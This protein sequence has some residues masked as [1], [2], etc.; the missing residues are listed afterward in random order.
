MSIVRSPIDSFIC[1]FDGALRAVS[2]VAV[3][4]RESPSS[5]L[6]QA[7]LT[8]EERKHSAGLMRVNHVGEVCAQALYEAQALF[9]RDELTRKQFKQ[10]GN[11]EL[12][13]LAWTAERLD[14]LNSRP[15]V[16]NPL[17]YAG[18]FAM[19]AIAARMGDQHSLGFVVETERQVEAHLNGHLSDLPL[20]DE[21]SRAIVMQMRDDEIEH[22]A[23]AQKLGAAELSEPVRIGMRAVSKVM[24]STAYY[25]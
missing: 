4:R 11:E 6:T 1:A 2:G 10:A 21:R 12:D 24:T 3:A 13:H 20:Q 14:E 22:G 5:K 7:K 18:A 23:A 8:E 16:L 17:W 19:G 9:A 15:S 25:L